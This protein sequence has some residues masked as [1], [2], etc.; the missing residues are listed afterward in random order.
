MTIFKHQIYNEETTQY[1]Y[2]DQRNFDACVQHQLK[3]I[4]E[5]AKQLIEAVAP[6][7]KQRNAALGLLPQ[8]EI[9][10]IKTDIQNI[11][12]ISNQKE[13]EILAVVW[14]GTESTR[15]AACDAVQAVRWD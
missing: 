2:I 10:Q 6:D 12:N 7:Y 1:T 3:V 9:D 11:R 8:T 4:R 13:T 15:P 14:D 5:K